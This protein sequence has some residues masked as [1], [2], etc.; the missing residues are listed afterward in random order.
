MSLDDLKNREDWSPNLLSTLRPILPLLCDR[1][2]TEIEVNG[3]DDIWAKSSL[4][5][6]HKKLDGIA[7]RDR[8]TL[9][10]ACVA[11]TECTGKIINEANPL[12]DGRLPGGERINVVVDPC[13]QK[14]CINIR[15]FPSDVMTADELLSYGSICPE[16]DLMIAGI[17]KARRTTLVSGGT[18]SGKTTLMNVIGGYINPALRVVTAEE[19]RELQIPVPNQVNL[20]IR[21]S[22]NATS[23]N[24]QLSDLVM[25]MLRMT[26]DIPIVG[27]IRGPEALY[28]LRLMS[29][30]HRGGLGSIHADSAVDALSQAQLLAML[31]PD[32]DFQAGTVAA[33]V[34]KAIDIVVH[35]E[36]L[37]EDGSRKVTEIIE[38]ERPGVRYL[39]HGVTEFRTRTLIEWETLDIT[40]ITVDGE[41]KPKVVGRWNFPHRPSAAFRKTIT[42]KKINW[43]ADSLNAS[44]PPNDLELARRMVSGGG[45][46]VDS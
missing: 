41:E 38:V 10:S 44:D 36:Q 24:V 22:M 29:T 32:A 16:I 8:A 19:N 13:C 15:K 31:S 33:M 4:W 27:E 5:R 12:Y 2:T 26:P 39:P 25:N 17:T 28:Y 9:R 7:F 1:T 18:N 30:G 14:V 21:A 40:T 23:R 42:F 6:G 11:L 35:V 45:Q 37:E 46:E 34:G 20:E 43:P 3:F